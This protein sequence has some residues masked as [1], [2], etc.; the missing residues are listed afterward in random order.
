[1]TSKRYRLAKQQKQELIDSYLEITGANQI[2]VE[3]LLDFVQQRPDHPFYPPLF[4]ADDSIHARKNRVA[5]LRKMLSGLRTTVQVVVDV[6]EAPP[7]PV[8]VE[9]PAVISP[10]A[11]R[12]DGGGYVQVRPTQP[13][14][15]AELAGQAADALHQWI[16]RYSGTCVMLGIDL[17]AVSAVEAQL[18][19]VETDAA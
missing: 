5:I 7:V 9:V 11:N 17:T 16:D 2:D 4:E 12:A 14:H 15:K 18:R 8:T 6:Q 19:G 10:R 3:A 13:D 1:M